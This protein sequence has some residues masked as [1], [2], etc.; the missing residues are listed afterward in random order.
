MVSA[1]G[2][3]CVGLLEW[4][5]VAANWCRRRRVARATSGPA[6]GPGVGRARHKPSR[7]RGSRA[8][9]LGRLRL[10]LCPL[11][12]GGR[13]TLLPTPVEAAARCQLLPPSARRGRSASCAA[14]LH[15]CAGARSWEGGASAPRNRCCRQIGQRSSASAG[16]QACRDTVGPFGAAVPLRHACPW[17]PSSA[18]PRPVRR[19]TLRAAEARRRSADNPQWS[20]Q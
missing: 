10:P 14:L 5:P 18:A 20:V 11:G 8:F 9:F 12:L 15:L 2:D 16:P 3:R 19:A 1:C 13:P 4:R 6:P 17:P 7:S